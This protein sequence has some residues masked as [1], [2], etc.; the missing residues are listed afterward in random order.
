MKNKDLATKLALLVTLLGGAGSTAMLAPEKTVDN[1]D[2][3]VR[4]TVESKAPVLNIRASKF[5]SGPGEVHN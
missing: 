1:T 3:S 5:S 4:P 2:N